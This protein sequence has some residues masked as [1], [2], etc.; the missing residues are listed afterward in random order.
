MEENVYK[1]LAHAEGIHQL[2]EELVAQQ[3]DCR[4]CCRAV[5]LPPKLA[6]ATLTSAEAPTTQPEGPR[7]IS[8]PDP[9]A[10]QLDM[11]ISIALVAAKLLRS[12]RQV[13]RYREAGK[14][15]FVQDDGEG[16]SGFWLSE[17]R[18]LYFDFYGKWP[19]SDGE[20]Q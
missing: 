17:V 4:K 10:G 15:T 3:R 19:R 8:K 18:R 5:E 1:I 11:V 14:L 7:L 12:E 13:R 20:G 16:R 6:D 9:M 2:M